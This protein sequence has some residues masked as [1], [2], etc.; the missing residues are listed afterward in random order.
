MFAHQ[1]PQR[2]STHLHGTA[3]HLSTFCTQP[4]PQHRPTHL[5]NTY[6]PVST[7][8][9]HMLPRPMPT[10]AHNTHPSLPT[11]PAHSCPRHPSSCVHNPGPLMSTTRFHTYP[12]SD[13]TRSHILRPSTST[14]YAH[15]HTWKATRFHEAL[16]EPRK[17]AGNPRAFTAKLGVQGMYVVGARHGHMRCA[18]SGLATLICGRVVRCHTWTH[19]YTWTRHTCPRCVVGA[20]VRPVRCVTRPRGDMGAHML[21]VRAHDALWTATCLCG[22]GW[23]YVDAILCVRRGPTRKGSKV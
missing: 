15:K 13:S 19:M 8:S 23:T 16:W 11:I 1:H 7:T 12:R 22:L 4:C 9:V 2:K 14:T 17:L 10:L 18:R 5:H 6:P 3:P 20:S 21:C